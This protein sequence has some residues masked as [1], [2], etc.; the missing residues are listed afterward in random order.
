MPK[1]KDNDLVEVA[2]YHAMMTNIHSIRGLTETRIQ[3]GKEVYHCY[4]NGKSRVAMQ[5]LNLINSKFN[6]YFVK[7][8]A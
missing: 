7:V 8:S 3:N 5:I 6:R 2:G 4:Y 1:T